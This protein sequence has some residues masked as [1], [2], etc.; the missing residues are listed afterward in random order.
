MYIFLCTKYSVHYINLLIFF[1]DLRLCNAVQF[2]SFSY[3][4]IKTSTKSIFDYF[5]DWLWICLSMKKK[6]IGFAFKWKSFY[7]LHYI[8]FVEKYGY[9][10]I[11]SFYIFFWILHIGHNAQ[12][13]VNSTKWILTQNE[14]DMLRS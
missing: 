7:I 1:C 13:C 9:F 10:Y 8:I 5:F 11:S 2:T 4:L 3:H 6:K 12:Y 14:F